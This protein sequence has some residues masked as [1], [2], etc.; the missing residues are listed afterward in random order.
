MN[1]DMGQKRKYI[2][3]WIHCL[4]VLFCCECTGISTEERE[5][6]A[7]QNAAVKFEIDGRG[8]AGNRP[9][10]LRVIF[11]R[12]INS[13]HYAKCIDALSGR[14]LADTVWSALKS[15]EYYVLAHG[16]DTNSYIDNLDRFVADQAVSVKELSWT[17]RDIHTDS[18]PLFEEEK[19][20]DFNP[21]YKYIRNAGPLYAD[22]IERQTLQRNDTTR[23]KLSPSPVT[24]KIRF[25]FTFRIEDGVEIVNV[26]GEISG[27]I[28]KMELLSRTVSDSVTCRVLFDVFEASREGEHIRYEGEI[29]VLGL[30]PSSYD[31]YITGPGILQLSICAGA[32]GKQKIF[33]AGI[34][35][36]Q[37]IREAGLMTET[38]TLHCYKIA[39]QEAE[40]T[41]RTIL[42]IRADQIISG[43][44][45][46]GVEKWYDQDKI[47][48]EV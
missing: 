22:V 43:T 35:L 18:L 26:R 32:G 37:V 19:W 17:I 21:G 31:S 20:V 47:D 29:N 28:P 15:G 30:L 3:V 24:Q 6:P 34:N 16:V 33:H 5:A 4:W 13:R 25:R 12:M 42:H 39:R 41:V 45:N 2:F 8:Y 46:N 9:D 10:S 38:E 44:A 48:V 7:N 23:I 27:V 11:S 36:K 1:R 40:L 14:P